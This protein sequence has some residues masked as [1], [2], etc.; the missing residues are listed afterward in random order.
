[1]GLK[2][3][4]KELRVNNRMSKE[5]DDIVARDIRDMLEKKTEIKLTTGKTSQTIKNM[6]GTIESRRENLNYS[7]YR[8]EI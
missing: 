6:T 2:L 7:S 4:K 3:T 5:K 8:K 1:M